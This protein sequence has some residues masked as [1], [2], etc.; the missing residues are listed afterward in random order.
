MHDSAA[1]DKLVWVGRNSKNHS[2]YRKNAEI[3]LAATAGDSIGFQDQE[4]EPTV[5][6]A[7]S[8]SSLK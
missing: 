6:G 8:K 3:W 4:C 2:E 5:V 1:K 7:L